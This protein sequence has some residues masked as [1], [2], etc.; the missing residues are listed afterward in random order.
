MKTNQNQLKCLLIKTCRSATTLSGWIA[1]S[2]SIT[3]ITTT[4]S[5]NILLCINPEII[6][7]YIKPKLRHSR[8]NMTTAK[9]SGVLS[10]IKQ[11]IKRRQNKY[12]V[13]ILTRV[14]LWSVNFV[15]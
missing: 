3:K 8:Q 14:Q 1:S 13:T 5:M 6:N 10:R 4:R 7:I 9:E 11:K 15:W 12:K 2:H